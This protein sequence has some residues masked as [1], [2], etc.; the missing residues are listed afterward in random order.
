[1]KFFITAIGSGN[2]LNY[3]HNREYG[4]VLAIAERTKENGF[5]YKGKNQKEIFESKFHM[6]KYKYKEMLISDTNLDVYNLG[7]LILREMDVIKSKFKDAKFHIELSA[8]Y[9][10]IGHVLTLISYIRSKDI[11][12][13]TFLRHNA[14]LEYLPI[15]KVELHEKEKEILNGFKNGVYFGWNGKINTNNYVRT[16]NKD[17]KYVY[18]VLKKCKE[19]GLLDENNRITD[20]GELYLEF[21]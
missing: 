2:T 14:K 3:P 6:T 16:Y 7:V 11:E 21:A 10:R 5:T 18:R 12:K 20:F 13:L 19:I 15:I 8:G 1:M 4:G 9:K 17:R